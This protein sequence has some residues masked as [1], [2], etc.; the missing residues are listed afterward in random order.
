MMLV[1]EGGGSRA[2]AA[3]AWDG[4][5]AARC[6]P[7]GVNP[8]DIGPDLLKERLQALVIPLLGLPDRQPMRLRAIASIAG[9]GRP[10]ARRK[11]RGVLEAVLRPRVLRLNLRVM[12]DAEALLGCFFN[13]RSGVVVIAGTGSVC[14]G[15]KHTRKD[16]LKV[17]AGGWGSYLDRGS[18]SRLGLRILEEALRTLDGGEKRSSTFDLLLRR[19]GMDPGDIPGR[20]LPPIRE[21]VASLAGLVFEASERGDRLAGRWVREA[22]SDLVD[23]TLAVAGR[24]RLGRKPLVVVS[25]GLFENPGFSAAF[26]RVLEHRLGSV[27]IRPVADPL[28]CMLLRLDRRA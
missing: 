3:L 1:I 17:R 7:V 11:C 10:E 4:K 27:S 14:L 18:G 8:N 15:V 6:L 9:S 22:V 13:R 23:M 19:Y 24:L 20:F 12:S 5:V 2:R 16:R 28:A 21:E 25:G 26:K